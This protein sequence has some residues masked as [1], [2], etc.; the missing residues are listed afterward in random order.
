MRQTNPRNRIFFPVETSK[1]KKKSTVTKEY[2]PISEFIAEHKGRR[3]ILDCG[4]KA[5]LGDGRS[6]TI[7]IHANGQTECHNC[8]Y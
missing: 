3:F 7:I 2:R 8:G 4:H 5:I 6:N 1:G